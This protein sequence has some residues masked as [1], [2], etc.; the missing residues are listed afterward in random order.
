MKRPISP[1]DWQKRC[2]F[3]DECD[4]T[5]IYAL[6][7]VRQQRP[8]N[9]FVVH[10]NFQSQGKGQ[11]GK[12]WKAAK[13]ENALFSVIYYPHHISPSDHFKL[14]KLVSVSL[15]RATRSFEPDVELYIKWPNDIYIGNKKVAGILIQNVLKG[16]LLDYSV[17]GIGINVNQKVFTEDQGRPTSLSVAFSKDVDP[18]SVIKRTVEELDTVMQPNFDKDVDEWYQGHLYLKG[19]ESTFKADGV[20]FNGVIEGVDH[21]GQLMIRQDKQLKAFTFG[22]IEYG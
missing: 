17:I 18:L 7:L 13:G 21:Q 5:N 1:D 16:K 20:W 9:G 8:Q 11:R 15:W 3:L 19:Q 6:D 12:S 2:V 10:T 14:N 4:S 22:E